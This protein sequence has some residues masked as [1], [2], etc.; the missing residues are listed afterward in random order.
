MKTWVKTYLIVAICMIGAGIIYLCLPLGNQE[1]SNQPSVNESEKENIQFKQAVKLDG[2]W[3]YRIEENKIETNEGWFILA[4]DNQWVAQNG[5]CEGGRARFLGEQVELEKN[6]KG[7]VTRISTAEDLT[8]P[9]RM[10]IVLSG[11]EDGYTHEMLSISCKEAFWAVWNGEIRAY[12][13]ETEIQVEGIKRRAIFYPSQEKSVLNLTTAKGTIPY[14]GQLEITLEEEGGYTVVN[15]VAV[16]TYLMGVVPS[17]M[18]GSYGVEA[19][20]VQAVCARSF[21]Y[22]QWM[23]NE[24]YANLGAQLDDSTKS[25]VY[26]GAVEYTASSQGVE[27]TWG[28]VLMYDGQLISTHYF[29]TSC[30]YTASAEEVWNGGGVCPYE[31]GKPQYEEGDYGDLSE[32]QNFH[33]FITNAE[34][35][36]FD[37]HSPWFRWTFSGSKAWLQG[38][39]D[40]FF[41]VEKTVKEVQEESLIEASITG[42]GE[43][44]DIFVYERSG[45]GMVRSLL[46]IGS[47]KSVVL[48]GPQAVRQLLGNSEVQ[49]SNGENAGERELLPS[50]FISL[51]KI[52][53]TEGNLVSLKI[54]G[55]GYGHGVGMSQNGVKGM[56]DAGYHYEQILAHYYEGS[57]LVDF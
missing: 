26:G 41:S 8:A 47:E 12:P 3:L 40:Q 22:S 16:E 7:E 4:E 43:I 37:Q 45:T 34:V 42:I 24:K 44:E 18:P 11:A 19:A 57:V 10:R 14:R 35:S 50:A 32:E 27:D 25:Q 20:K 53:D 5:Q 17:E 15:E 31:Q 51:E 49:L 38:Q 48:E 6:E 1:E 36:A 56:I 13:P 46:L 23:S 2:T 54:C 39:V 30:G 55:G 9:T 52:K 28:K 33:Q 21:A 29:S